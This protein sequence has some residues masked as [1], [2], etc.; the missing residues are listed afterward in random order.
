M[1][2]RTLGG[3]RLGSGKKMEVELRGF[4]RSNH[5]LSYVWRSTMAAGTLVPFMSEVLLPGDTFDINLECEVLTKPTIGPLYG[6]YKVQ[7][8]V[9]EAPIRLYQ[10]KLHN[11]KLGIGNDMAKVKLP[12]FKLWGFRLDP[13]KSPDN[14]QMNPS[15]IFKYLGI[16][17]IGYSPTDALMRREFNAVPWLGYWDIYKN[18]YANKQENIGAVLAS[19]LAP[20]TETVNTFDLGYPGGTT[21]LIPIEDDG[22][23]GELQQ[24]NDNKQAIIT[25]TGA[26]PKPEEIMLVVWVGDG[27]YTA[28]SINQIWQ[29]WAAIDGVL[30]GTGIIKPCWVVNWRYITPTDNKDALPEVRTFPLENLDVMR[31]NILVAVRSTGAYEISAE[32][33]T[34][35]SWALDIQNNRLATL[36]SQEGLAIK[37]YQSDLFLHSFYVLL[38]CLP[39]F[40]PR[41]FGHL[42]LRLRIYC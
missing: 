42:S 25:F 17:G 20:V 13:T 3:D 38:L 4:E 21:V 14:Q 6:S 11:N 27:T 2:K 40:V 9:F 33:V 37:T 12:V 10:A 34:P 24:V 36:N 29:N 31:E 41:S 5:D 26:A 18:Y 22:T 28:V 15:C 39:R 30:Y 7:L 8:D 16:S 1:Q 32:D 23:P 35:Y 19:G